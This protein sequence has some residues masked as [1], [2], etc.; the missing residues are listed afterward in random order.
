VH[1]TPVTVLVLGY[2]N[3]VKDGAVG[4]A[5]YGAAGPRVRHRATRYC[6]LALRRAAQQTGARY[7]PTTA[8]FR[9]DHRTLDPTGLLGAGRGP[10]ERRRAGG[11]RRGGLRRLPP[12]DA[13]PPVPDEAERGRGQRDDP[14]GQVGAEHVAVAVRQLHQRQCR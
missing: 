6:N 1:G 9:G 5:A 14:G 4:L 12:G 2:W 7:V 13:A 8:T 10:P 11:D 3:V